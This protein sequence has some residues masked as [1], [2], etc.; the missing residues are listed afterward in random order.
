M[1]RLSM[2]LGVLLL[3]LASWAA[4]QQTA[5]KP[6]AQKPPASGEMVAVPAGP[7]TMGCSGQG[8]GCSLDPYDEGPEHEVTLSAFEIDKTEVTQRAYQA[9]VKAGKC[10]PPEANFDPA[11][12]ANYP[13]TNVTWGQAAAYCAWA[14]KRLPTE[15]EWEKAARGTDVRK[16]PWGSQEPTCELANFAGCTPPGSHPVGSHP[17]GASPYGA[18][19]MAGNV[20][21]W[22]NDWYGNTYDTRT[23]TDPQGPDE[24]LG[25]TKGRRGG[26]FGGEA[27]YVRA[28]NRGNVFYKNSKPDVGFRCAK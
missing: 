14:G 17:Q 10:T 19:D 24:V 2:A 12:K 23:K 18:L 5:R 21:E 1:R 20:S 28:P 7:F 4:A 6:A 22:V 9:C 26:S 25:E 16:Y 27:E 15:A 8:K 13:V 3:A 11:G